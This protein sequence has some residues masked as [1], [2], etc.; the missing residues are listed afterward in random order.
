MG[1]QYRGKVMEFGESVLAHL[2]EEGKDRD[3]PLR[4]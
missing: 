3:A 2:P 1:G 4:N